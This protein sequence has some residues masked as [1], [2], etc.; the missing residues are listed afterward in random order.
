MVI[1]AGP[2]VSNNTIIPFTNNSAL[3]IGSDLDWSYLTV[4]QTGLDNRPIDNLAGKAPGGGTAIN[5][6][7]ISIPNT[8]EG[9]LLSETGGWI[10]GDVADYDEW[11]DIAGDQRWSY[12]GTLP[13]MEATEHHWTNNFT[14]AAPDLQQYGFSGPVWDASVYFHWTGLPTARYNQSSLGISWSTASSRI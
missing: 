6:C 9:V 10:R 13:Y 12:Q 2:D 4:P 11:A 14:P 1:E 3:L 5:S 7:K 8:F